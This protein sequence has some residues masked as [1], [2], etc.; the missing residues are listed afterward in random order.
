MTTAS[1]PVRYEIENT[2]DTVSSSAM[3]QICVSVIS[4][5]GYFKSSNTHTVIRNTSTVGTDFYPLIAVRMAPGR[6]DSVIIPGIVDLFQV[7]DG[8]FEYAI[9]KNPSDISGGTWVTHPSTGNVEY[10]ISATSMTDGDSLVSGFFGSGN[11]STPT[12]GVDATNFALQLGRTNSDTPVSDVIV[13]AVKVATG[14]GNVKCSLGWH[15]LL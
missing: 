6:T 11:R 9:I 8:D 10:N 1:L 12:A 14:T 13:L 7:T 3:K 15:D 2:G 4:N 5:G